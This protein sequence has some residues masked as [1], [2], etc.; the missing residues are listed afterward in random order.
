MAK[1]LKREKKKELENVFKVILQ[2]LVALKKS[3]H[4]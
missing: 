1:P 2:L 3:S 4:L